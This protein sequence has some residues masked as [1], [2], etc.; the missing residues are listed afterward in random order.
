VSLVAHKVIL[1]EDSV[2]NNNVTSLEAK[3][4]S[5]LILEAWSA[6]YSDSGF[7]WDRAR[8]EVVAALNECSSQEIIDEAYRLAYAKWENS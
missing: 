6:S 7:L 4:L 2:Q 1:E 3:R 5:V 8:R